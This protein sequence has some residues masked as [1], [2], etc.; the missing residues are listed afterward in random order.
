MSNEEVISGN[1]VQLHYTGTFPDGEVFD[2]SEGKDP[3]E[4]IA[5][6]GMLIKGFDNALIGM[7]PGEEKEIDIKAED[8]YGEHR[9]ELIREINKEELGDDMKPEVGMMLGIRAPTGQVFPAT[10]TEVHE[11]T[12]KLDANHPLAGK[13]LH[14]KIAIEATREPTDADMEKFAP[15]KEAGGCCGGN[16]SE[17]GCGDNCS[18]N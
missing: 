2:S 15:K 1:F 16:C 9:E 5:G 14:F 18:C 10:I 7:K 13:D 12:I 3:L 6:K 8:A 11:E 17:G 4:V